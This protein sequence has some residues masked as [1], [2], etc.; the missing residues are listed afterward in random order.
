MVLCHTHRRVGEERP[1]ES[2][3]IAGPIE[4]MNLCGTYRK[5]DEKN[6]LSRSPIDQSISCPFMSPIR[7][8]WKFFHASEYETHFT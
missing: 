8:Y 5:G 3:M 4:I 6:H 2:N 7:L 1:H